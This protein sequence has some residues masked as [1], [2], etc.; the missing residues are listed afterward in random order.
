MKN[1]GLAVYNPITGDCYEAVSL[2]ISRDD[3]DSLFQNGGIAEILPLSQAAD[4]FDKIHPSRRIIELGP[5]VAR[6]MGY[7]IPDW[8]VTA[9][10]ARHTYRGIYRFGNL[11]PA[12][13]LVAAPGLLYSIN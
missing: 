3:I 12:G 2:P 6:Y 1:L 4:A 13:H 5:V 8:F 11:I 9:D 7:G 10:G